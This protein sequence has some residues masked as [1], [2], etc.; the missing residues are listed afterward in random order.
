[1]LVSKIN[2]SVDFMTY[3]N[4]TSF[5]CLTLNFFFFL[6][7]STLFRG[8]GSLACVVIALL[9]TWDQP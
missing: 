5:V 9:V 3:L 1:M 6:T 4:S 2:S 7:F 8:Q